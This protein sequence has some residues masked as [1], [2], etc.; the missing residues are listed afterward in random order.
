MEI[1][2]PCGCVLT[3]A[4]AETVRSRLHTAIRETG[5][6]RRKPKTLKPCPHCGK[7]FGARAL[8]A[9][10]PVCPRNKLHQK[11]KCRRCGK[12]VLRFNL[13]RHEKKCALVGNNA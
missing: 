3:R 8:A 10:M 13:A 1:Q 2:S 11:V 4:Q 5:N 9:H 12:Q 6:P 7:A